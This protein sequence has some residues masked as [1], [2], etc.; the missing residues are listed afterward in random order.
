LIGSD[1]IPPLIETVD[2]LRT[3]GETFLGAFVDDQLAGIASFTIDDGTIDIHRL[4]VDPSFFRRGIGVALVRATLAAEPRARRA[5][6]QTGAA[7]VP[8]KSLYRAEG[9][10]EI[11]ERDVGNAVRVALFELKLHSSS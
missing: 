1:A 11:G 2:E 7:N 8:A 9:F 10:V 6:V 4:A 5:I 3:C